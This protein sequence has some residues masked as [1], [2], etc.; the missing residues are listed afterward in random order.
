MSQAVNKDLT[1]EVLSSMSNWVSNELQL[2]LYQLEKTVAQTQ[3]RLII[4]SIPRKN[5]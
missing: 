5:L 4:M 2:R 1:N 3:D